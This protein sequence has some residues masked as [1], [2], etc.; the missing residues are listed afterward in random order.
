MQS[1]GF[2]GMVLGMVIL[3]VAVGS[4]GDAKSANIV[5]VIA[6]FSIFNLMMNMGPNSTTFGLPALLFPAEIRATAAG[7]SA[8]CPEGAHASERCGERTWRGS[9]LR[10]RHRWCHSV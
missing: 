10:H 9:D 8:G 6:G 4:S 1:I 2:L 5:L 7:S 3:V